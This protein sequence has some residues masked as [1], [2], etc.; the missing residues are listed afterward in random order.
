MEGQP[1]LT[2][3]CCVSAIPSSFRY[4]AKLIPP[5]TSHNPLAKPLTS[6]PLITVFLAYVASCYNHP[7]DPRPKEIPWRS[8]STLYFAVVQLTTIKTIPQASPPP[9]SASYKIPRPA[10]TAPLRHTSGASNPRSLIA[11]VDE[12]F[13]DISLTS[14]SSFGS[15]SRS[16][17]NSLQQVKTARYFVPIENSREA[18]ILNPDQK[19]MGKSWKE[20]GEKDAMESLKLPGT[21]III[22]D[23]QNWRELEGV[24]WM[25]CKRHEVEFEVRAWVKE[26]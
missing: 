26:L 24:E 4:V 14:C 15:P 22:G 10:S 19:L 18:T 7:H 16:R 6:T 3:F 13:T 25:S 23:G 9:A 20:I 5:S 11:E 2:P 21:G 17:S 1:T 8:P 12:G